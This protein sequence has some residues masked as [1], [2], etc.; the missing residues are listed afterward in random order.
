MVG[1]LLYNTKGPEIACPQPIHPLPKWINMNGWEDDEDKTTLEGDKKRIAPIPGPTY[2]D[3][4]IDSDEE[5]SFPHQSL[6]SFILSPDPDPEEL[7]APFFHPSSDPI[8]PPHTSTSLSPEAWDLPLPCFDPN[9]NSPL[10]P[11]VEP[12]SH[13][14]GF[15]RPPSPWPDS[16]GSIMFP[17]SGNLP[18]PGFEIHDRIG[19]G[20]FWQFPGPLDCR[21]DQPSNR[22]ARGHA[23][24]RLDGGFWEAALSGEREVSGSE[25]YRRS[26]DWTWDR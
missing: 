22:G 26:L 23:Y 8:P 19:V 25:H 11:D 9:P 10:V 12:R 7:P 5:L 24:W 13:L 2:I 18:P 15:E 4:N 20:G 16:F 17:N 6:L 21:Q 1:D 3:D 14:S